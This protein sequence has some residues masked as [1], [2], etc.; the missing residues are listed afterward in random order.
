M[1]GPDHGLVGL[2]ADLLEQGQEI[3][4]LALQSLL[5]AE[6]EQDGQEPRPDEALLVVQRALE[7]KQL[8]EQARDLRRALQGSYQFENLVGKSP[9]MLPIPGA[10]KERN[11]RDSAAAMKL[12]LTAEDVATIDQIVGF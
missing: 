1:V 9:V 2:G 4:D 7:R 5:V 11:A 12:R 8:R 3:G 10:S 6:A